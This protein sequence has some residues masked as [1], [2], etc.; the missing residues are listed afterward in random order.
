MVF[1]QEAAFETAL[2]NLRQKN[3][4]WEPEILRCKTEEDLTKTGNR[5]S[6]KQPGCG[7]AERCSADRRRNAAD[8]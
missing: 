4:A 1:E 7:P 5:S 2:I 3:M 6:L 8:S